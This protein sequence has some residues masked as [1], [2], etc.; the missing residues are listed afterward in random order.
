[1][2]DI[3]SP[4]SSRAFDTL[5]ERLG[6]EFRRTGE[7]GEARRI[8]EGLGEVKYFHPY[9]A[10]REIDWDKALVEAIPKVNAARTPEDYQ[11]ALNQMLAVL[12]DKSTR[13]ERE[14]SE[15]APVPKATDARLVRTENGA[16]IIEATRVAQA[17]AKDVTAVNGFVT[18]INQAI[19]NSS[20]VIIDARGTGKLTEIEAYHFENFMR[21]TLTGMLDTTV[22]LG[23][24]RYRMHNG[25]ATQTGG[26]ASFYYSA[27][28]NSAPQTING[29]SKTKTPPIAFIIN[30]HTPSFAG[31]LS[32]LQSARQQIASA[33]QALPHRRR[34]D[35]TDVRG[36]G[37]LET[38]DGDE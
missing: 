12:N 8:G 35:A 31:V 6:S 13:A 23:S 14:A 9:L 24:T 20:S 33:L 28:V 21:Q 30:E 19:T 10:Y 15:Q 7:G 1:M 36:F 26:G 37:W 16:L 25:Y 18:S 29:R 4:N 3:L 27:L 22:T 32:G 11:N 38:F 34:A 5:S 17:A 2:P